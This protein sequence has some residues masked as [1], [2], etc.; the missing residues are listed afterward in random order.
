MHHEM[1]AVIFPVRH[2]VSA[3]GHVSDHA[4][5]EALRVVRCLK[6][7]DGDGIFRVKLLCDPAGDAVQFHAVH[8]ESVHPLRNQAHKVPNPAGRL[9]KVPF[10]QTHLSQRFIHGLYHYRRRIKGIQG[11]F[12]C[13]PVFLR[14]K[15]HIQLYKL[16]RPVFAPFLKCLGKSAPPYITG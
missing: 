5:K 13:F 12:L 16:I 9:Q 14:I 15:F 6:S 10:L 4:V 3:V 7:L 2:L 1:V 11:G 8:V